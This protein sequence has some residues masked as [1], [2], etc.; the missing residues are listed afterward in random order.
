MTQFESANSRAVSLLDEPVLVVKQKLKLVELRNEYGV[1]DPGGRQVGAVTQVGQSPLAFLARLFTSWDVALPITLEIRGPSGPELLVQKP[2][3][4]WRCQVTRPDG[5]PLG[6]IVKQIRLGKAR[7][8]LLDPGGA[9]LGEVR[10]ENWR[11]KDFSVRD[12]AG[13]ELAR[14][15]KRWAGLRELFTDADT[16]VVEV[17]PAAVDPLRSLAVASCLVIDVIMKQKDT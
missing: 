11:A 5:L 4:T 17:L 9:Q 10:A 14:V 15:T 1:F 6:Q 13:Q 8:T 3:F 16:Y 7:F 12:G 2:W